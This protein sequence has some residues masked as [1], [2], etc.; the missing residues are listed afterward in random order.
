MS[1]YSI[2]RFYQDTAHADHHK[3]IHTELTL[4][5]AKEHCNSDESEEEGVWF[6]GFQEE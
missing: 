3:V 6:D 5:E 2:V 4:E 1:T